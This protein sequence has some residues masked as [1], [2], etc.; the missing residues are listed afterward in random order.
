MEELKD[1][2]DLLR[3]VRQGDRDAREEIIRRHRLFIIRVAAGFCKRQ[4]VWHDDE[5]SIALIAF[6]EALDVF[7]DGRGVPFPAFAR[8]VIRS[9]IADYYRKEVQVS[10]ENLKETAVNGRTGAEVAL[11]RFTEAELTSERR[12]EIE[13]YRTLLTRFGLSF[14]DLVAAAPKHRD[15]RAKLIQ[16]ARVLAE[17]HELLGQLL[18]KKRVPLNELSVLT[19]VPRKTLERGR[20]YILAV[21]LILGRPDEFPHLYSHLKYC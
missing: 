12:E 8:L 18:D 14:K 7:D 1:R 19:G 17:N 3:R 16:V 21:G 2:E 15:A 5:A 13:R 9:R 20:R 10:V 4:I 6:N 11:V